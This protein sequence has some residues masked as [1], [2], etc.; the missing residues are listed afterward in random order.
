MKTVTTIHLN[1]R[2][3]QVEDEAYIA[4]RDYLQKAGEALEENPDKD[5]ILSDFEQAIAEKCARFLSPAKNV[6]TRAEIHEVISEMGPVEGE[7]REKSENTQKKETGS[8]LKP[9]RL[10]RDPDNRVV[11]GVASG[12]AQYFN[13]D[14]III[15]IIFVISVFLGGTGILIYIILW[16]AVPEA[17]SAAQKL[18]MRGSNVNL[19]GMAEILKQKVDEVP[20]KH[21]SFFAKLIDIPRS[22]LRAIGSLIQTGILPVVR[23]LFG[24]L[25]MCIGFATLVGTTIVLGL[26]LFASPTGGSDF[27]HL[28]M[29]ATTGFSVALIAGY[30]ATILPFLALFLAGLGMIEKKNRFRKGF[31]LAFLTLWFMA[32]I[33]VSI[34]GTRSAMDI[35]RSISS[36]PYFQ[37]TTETHS[38]APFTKLEVR[39]GQNVTFLSGDTYSIDA[40]GRKR[41]LDDLSIESKDGI[42]TIEERSDLRNSCFIFCVGSKQVEIIITAPNITDITLENGSHFEGD[43]TTP[44]FKASL[45]NGSRADVSLI[46][47]TAVIELENASSLELKG[48]VE[49]IQLEVSNASQYEGL[50]VQ[51]KTVEATLEN[52]SYA[53]V[54]ASETLTVVLK[55]GSRLEYAG[56]PKIEKELRNGSVIEAFTE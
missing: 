2:A 45:K 34:A 17:E 9:K 35:R 32:I 8:P 1:G 13:I 41:E 50:N 11:A 52:G 56:S 7:S 19:A 42:L 29:Y 26:I 48:S 36:D 28:T 18:E 27:S 33:V 22:I 46:G 23:A 15:R 53:E 40:H 16:I 43:L 25:C 54:N 38:P 10:Y 55:N 51:S 47:T 3:Y 4:L 24:V 6:I 49:T 21:P 31:G 14:P 30:I 5:E 12:I 39:N 37:E 44:A 20:K